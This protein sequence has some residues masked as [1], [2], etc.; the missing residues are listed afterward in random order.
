MIKMSSIVVYFNQ[1]P[2]PVK[3]STI[4]YLG[5]LVLYNG[6]STYMNSKETLKSHRQKVHKKYFVSDW[7]AVK[8]GAQENF[9]KRL[10]DSILWPV[11]SI[12]N[13]IPYVVL[14]LNP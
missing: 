11:T 4:A 7:D 13:L 2:K 1:L 14:K 3:Y 6:I 10:V 5:T 8:Y 9:G 12:Q